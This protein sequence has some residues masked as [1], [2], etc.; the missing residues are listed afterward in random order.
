MS[1][2]A[3]KKAIGAFVVVALA[4]ALVAIVVFG[5]GKFFAETSQY[6][7]FFQGSVK[8]LKVGA[9]VVFRGVK[10][11]E[12]TKM[13][14]YAHHGD[15]SYDIPVILEIEQDNFES[16]GPEIKDEKQYLQELIKKGLRARLQL[17]S[18]V[19]GQ[20]MINI[21]FYP[22]SPVNLVGTD[23][24]AIA[25][26]LMEVPTIPTPMQELEKTLEEIPLGEIVKSV[27]KSLEAIETLLT[28]EEL[29][30]SLGHFKQSMQEI[31]DLARHVDEKIDPLA[32]ELDQT[33]KDAQT[34]LRKVNS[35]VDP[36]AV[37]IQNTVADAR[38]A[39]NEVERAFAN[40]ADLTAKGSEERKQLDRTLKEF[41]AAARSIRLWAEYLERHPE[42]LIRGKG[43]SKRR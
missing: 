39:V 11:G 27:T 6:V 42:A 43:K 8:G 7:A 17:Q 23:K 4:L 20:L 16:I 32:A 35:H 41:Q 12:V 28:S 26:G 40:L 1:K 18:I 14:I 21:D 19:T 37:S 3:N 24:I 30:K 15:Q 31:R 36:L 25:R 10:I 5:S 38:P 29:T 2:Q 33:L 22:N 34:L 13:M 9:P